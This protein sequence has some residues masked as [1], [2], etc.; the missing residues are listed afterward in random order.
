MS[1]NT[2]F[3]PH[4]GPTNPMTVRV[5][6]HPR[7]TYDVGERSLVIAIRDEVLV[8]GSA[9]E[10]LRPELALIGTPVGTLGAATS[11]GEGPQPSEFDDAA[12]GQPFALPD[13]T[14]IWR[15]TSPAENSIDVARR[16]RGL[17]PVSTVVTRAGAVLHI[18]PISPNHVCSVASH[19]NV[20]PA[21][22]PE[23]CPPPLAAAHFVEAP[24]A[25]P[26][27]RVVVIDTGYINTHP[28]HLALDERVHS[29]PGVWLDTQV[30]PARW[31]LSPPD[32]LDAD[33]D[34]R[35]DAVAGHGTFIAALIA[36][37][38]RQSEILVVGERYAVAELA[39]DPDPT[40]QAMLFADEVSV[41]RT[42]LLHGDAD[43]VSCGFAFPTLDG[44]PS[45]PFTAAMQWLT[46][47]QAPRPGVAVVSPAGNEDSPEPY[48]PAAHPD[49]VGVASTNR[50][51]NARAWFS[52]WGTWADCC[53]RGEHVRSMFIYWRGPVEGE[54]VHDI[55]DFDGWARWDGT[56]FAA[57]KVTAAIARLVAAGD[58]SL[59]PVDAW[60]QLLTGS[61]GVDVT[62][63]SA[64]LAG[65]PV[66]LPH[67]HLG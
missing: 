6:A 22:P 40:D 11:P 64:A 38:A 9:L 35:L 46:S 28:P 54:P 60:T 14:H 12:D 48:W 19:F 5:L 18:P 17:A 8:R 15:L 4:E 44:A 67:L 25:G 39:P 36:H 13:D 20:C 41:A 23:P 59:A 65:P 50:W 47:S 30:T 57:P 55:E 63:L 58:G 32:T 7:V 66:T 33:H 16:L 27:A 43:V 21:S 24:E 51:G 26:R 56:S 53:T 10:A 62:P 52:N 42:L 2:V 34:G 31:R 1:P 49:V 45:L 3:P 37:R 61:G 29:I